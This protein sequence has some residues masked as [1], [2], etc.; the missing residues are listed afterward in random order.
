MARRKAMRRDVSPGVT[1]GRDLTRPELS[2]TTF[3]NDHSDM[4]YG[5]Y[6]DGN[7]AL[8]VVPHPSDAYTNQELTPVRPREQFD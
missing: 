8:G 3:Q 7:S 4:P 2:A 6:L 1:L 5:S